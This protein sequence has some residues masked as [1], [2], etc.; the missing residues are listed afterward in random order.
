MQ[1]EQLKRPEFI[2]LIGSAAWQ[3]LESAGDAGMLAAADP[4]RMQ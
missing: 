1:F 2:T 3:S 4:Q